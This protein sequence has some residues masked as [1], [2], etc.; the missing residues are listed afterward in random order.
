[1]RPLWPHMW[2]ICSIIL[3]IIS[4]FS[5]WAH[6][7]AGECKY[8]HQKHSSAAKKC[9]SV[10]FYP[11]LSWWCQNCPIRELLVSLDNFVFAPLVSL[12]QKQKTLS[13]NRNRTRTNIFVPLIRTKLAE[14]QVWKHP[15]SDTALTQRLN[16]QTVDLDVVS[17]SI[18]KRNN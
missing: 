3:S 11:H 13:V 8:T 9:Q 18:S 16:S 6:C 1:M 17:S 12:T 5:S 7:D 14:R 10:R 4:R 15:H 2:P